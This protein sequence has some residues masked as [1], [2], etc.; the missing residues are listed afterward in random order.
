MELCQQFG[1]FGSF[2]RKRTVVQR[3][4]TLPRLM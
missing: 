3:D 1:S 2:A 4:E